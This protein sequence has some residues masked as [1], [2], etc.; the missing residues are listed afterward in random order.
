MQSTVHQ[1]SIKVVEI[2]WGLTESAEGEAWM[3]NGWKLVKIKSSS[4]RA[5][6]INVPAQC[7]CFAVDEASSVCWVFTHIGS[8]ASAWPCMTLPLQSWHHLGFGPASLVWPSLL[9]C[10]DLD[11]FRWEQAHLILLYCT[12]LHFTVV[13]FYTKCKQDPPPGK[14]VTTCFS[15]VVWNLGSNISGMSVSWRLLLA[16]DIGAISL[17][18]A[19]A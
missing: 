14:K 5:Q 3:W 10:P 11:F 6:P 18:S 9:F 4:T 7:C 12:L 15:A 8:L 16:Y 13:V 1:F 17:D 19:S 2:T